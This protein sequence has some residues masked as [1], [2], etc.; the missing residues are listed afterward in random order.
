MKIAYLILAAG[1]ASRFGA[2]KQLARLPTGQTII[3]QAITR[4]PERV[5]EDTYVVVGAYRDQ[6]IP[7]LRGVTVMVHENWAAGLG[8]S[9]SHGVAQVV[10]QG[11]YDAILIGLADQVAVTMADLD[12][13]LDG[14]SKGC[15]VCARYAG[16]RGVPALFPKEKFAELIALSGD[17]GAKKLLNSTAGDVMEIDLPNAQYDID[18]V[19]DLEAFAQ[20]QRD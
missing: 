5:R 15:V 14:A 2:S 12:R 19:R 17:S 3:E 18:T 10:D 13:M 1:Q 7:L 6:I 16:Q 4:L 9:L 20:G 11:A 8:S